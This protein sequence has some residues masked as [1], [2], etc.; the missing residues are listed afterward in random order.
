MNYL[1]PDI[2]VIHSRNAKLTA[3]PC[4]APDVARAAYLF[5]IRPREVH[6][7]R[8]NTDMFGAE[9]LGRGVLLELAVMPEAKN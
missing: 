5:H 2:G 8:Q 7:H 1:Y 9:M 4:K 6:F 3:V